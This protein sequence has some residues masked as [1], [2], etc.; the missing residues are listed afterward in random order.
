MNKKNKPLFYDES[1]HFVQK[2]VVF[3]LVYVE[4]SCGL[5]LGKGVFQ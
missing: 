1:L 5:L 3:L 4:I 2:N